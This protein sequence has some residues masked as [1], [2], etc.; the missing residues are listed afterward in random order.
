M[1]WHKGRYSATRVRGVGP[2][3]ESHVSLAVLLLVVQIIG[4]AD[5]GI[6]IS[7]AVGLFVTAVYVYRV[8]GLGLILTN[9][10]LEIRR[11]FRHA[12]LDRPVSGIARMRP[13]RVIIPCCLEL[14]LSDGRVL[15]TSYVGRR[16]SPLEPFGTAALPTP[17]LEVLK[18]LLEDA[19]LDV[20]QLPSEPSVWRFLQDRW[21]RR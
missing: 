7:R 19:G 5:H 21:R 4:V 16:T 9:D 15:R 3:F 2:G 17:Y 11:V 20:K 8:W 12:R 14:R 13:S 18:E 1:I 6:S 10:A